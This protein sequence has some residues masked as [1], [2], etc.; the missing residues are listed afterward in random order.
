[1]KQIEDTFSAQDRASC[2]AHESELRLQSTHLF[3][4]VCAILVLNK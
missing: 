4:A 2:L 3:R 1:M